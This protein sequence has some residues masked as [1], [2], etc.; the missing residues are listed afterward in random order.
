M[1]AERTPPDSPESTGDDASHGSETSPL[2]ARAMTALLRGALRY[3]FAVVALATGLAVLA[4]AYSALE[5]GYKQPSHFCRCFKE[6]FGL[7]PSE[8][9]RSVSFQGTENHH[10]QLP[11]AALDS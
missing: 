4:T 3:P 1:T 11:L 6:W 2:A 10:C 5:L 8:V 9:A 7:T